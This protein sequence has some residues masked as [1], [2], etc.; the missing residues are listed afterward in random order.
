MNQPPI[1]PLFQQIQTQIESMER[2][3]DHAE[4]LCRVLA[5]QVARERAAVVELR[6]ALEAAR[7][8]LPREPGASG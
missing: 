6:K 4:A 1:A 7:L 2:H 5:G 8:I 3:A